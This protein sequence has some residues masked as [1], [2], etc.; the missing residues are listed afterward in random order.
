MT[1]KEVVCEVPEEFIP[2]PA[3]EIIDNRKYLLSKIFSS[4]VSE[5]KFHI[6]SHLLKNNQ[7]LKV[8]LILKLY[9]EENCWVVTPCDFENFDNICFYDKQEALEFCRFFGFNVDV[10]CLNS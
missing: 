1:D 5:E 4:G 2:I 3:K 7:Q 6:F 9:E 10:S 8:K